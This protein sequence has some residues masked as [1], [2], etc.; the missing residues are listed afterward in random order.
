MKALT[1]L[2]PWASLTV[3][4]WESGRFCKMF[5][6]RSYRTN[7]RGLLAIHSSAR[8]PKGTA[9]ICSEEP[10]R[11][12]LGITEALQ[13]VT[14]PRIINLDSVLP[15]GVILGVCKVVDCMPVE[16]ALT[17]PLMT[18]QEKCFGNYEPGRFAW[19][20]EEMKVLPWPIKT[21]GYQRF[22]NFPDRNLP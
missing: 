12:A 14:C 18:D 6:T 17:H 7:H 10:F 8:I 16:V 1:L 2:Q 20:L 5:E 21:R 11:S 22:W 19:L 13:S 3:I 9:K 4:R 15:V